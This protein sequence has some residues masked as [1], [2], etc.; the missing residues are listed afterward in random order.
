MSFTWHPLWIWFFIVRFWTFLN[1]RLHR[2]HTLALQSV[3][4]VMVEGSLL[5]SG[6]W[7]Y[8]VE[9]T[10][11]TLLNKFTLK[12][13]LGYHV[14][15]DNFAI[16]RIHVYQVIAKQAHQLIWSGSN[17]RILV[18]NHS[19]VVC[20]HAY[21]MFSS[22]YPFHSHFLLSQ[23][24][25]VTRVEVHASG[26]LRPTYHNTPGRVPIHASGHVSCPRKRTRLRLNIYHLLRNPR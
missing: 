1:R 5:R 25:P 20:N 17:M 8:L 18:L 23:S 6:F 7:N 4:V 11:R 15:P 12:P 16:T 14:P 21:V 3:L 13:N 2:T 26:P 9:T 10:V 19:H 24:S 22:H